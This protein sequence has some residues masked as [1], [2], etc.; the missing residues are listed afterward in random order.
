MQVRTGDGLESTI[1]F[2]P[3]MEVVIAKPLRRMGLRVGETISV[4]VTD[5]HLPDLHLLIAGTY[6]QAD[7][8]VP[9][10]SQASLTRTFLPA[11]SP[12]NGPKDGSAHTL[13]SGRLVH[14][15]ATWL[16]IEHDGVTDLIKLSPEAEGQTFHPGRPSDL[17]PGV[18]VRLALPQG[19]VRAVLV[20]P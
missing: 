4:S 19:G 9:R 15:G 11:S 14:V 2:S 20:T 7:P 8:S 1:A 18:T 6:V 17:H 16:D 10:H 13:I 12:G 5:I 3:D